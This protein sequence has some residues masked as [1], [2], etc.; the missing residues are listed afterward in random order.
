[1]FRSEFALLAF[2]DDFEIPQVLM[3]RKATYADIRAYVKSNFGINVTNYMLGVQDYVRTSQGV[4]L[5]GDEPIYSIFTRA[6]S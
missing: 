1:M 5:T 3:S 6:C 4:K 2:I